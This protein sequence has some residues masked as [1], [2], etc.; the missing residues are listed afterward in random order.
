MEDNLGRERHGRQINKQKRGRRRQE[1]PLMQGTHDVEVE[2]SGGSGLRAQV[3]IP[4][5]PEYVVEDQYLDDETEWPDIPPPYQEPQQQ[6][7]EPREGYGGGPTNLSL[8]SLYHKQRT[9]LI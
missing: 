1:T 3:H 2:S 7:E 4:P 6:L 8:L 9:I 5:E